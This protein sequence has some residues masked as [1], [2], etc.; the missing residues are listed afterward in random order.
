VRTLIHWFRR[1]LRVADNTAL[2][3]A[4]RDAERVVPVFLLDDHYAADP[5][6]GPARL[7]FL[8]ESLEEL[9]LSLPR[10]GGS[11]LVRRG[12]AAT[13]LPQLLAETGADGVYANLEIG[14]YPE[15]RDRLAQAAVEAAGARFRLFGDA[16]LV[17][18]DAIASAAGDPYTVYTPFSRK[19]TAAEKRDPEPSPAS[20]ESPELPGIPLATVRAWRDLPRDARCLPGGETAALELLRRFFGGPAALY[21]ED[22]NRPDRE[23][24]SRLSPYL[25]FGTISPRTIRAAAE[26]SW[27]A[28]PPGGREHI[29]KFVLELAW[30]EFYQHVLFHFPRVARESFRPEFDALAWKDDAEAL[31]AWK[32]GRTGY[33]FVDASMRELTTTHWMHNRSRMV[34]AS[35]LTKD[36]HIHWRQGEQWFEH[37][38]ADADLA[39]NNGGW[40]WAAGSGTDAAPYF[41]VFNPVLQ[42]RKFDPEGSYIR[43]YVPE[44]A[45]VPAGKLH[46]PWTMTS[47]EQV[48]SGC[49]IGVDYPAPIVDHAREKAVALEMFA[50]LRK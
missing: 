40:Q 30:R 35:F 3:R 46:E 11:L 41:R 49:R 25:H 44:L 29:R 17:E 9:A 18:P 10:A 14:P 16:L 4:A 19:W 20:L 36:L 24:T 34:A 33:P 2:S 37:E 39:S 22:R 31:L 26:E 28:T 23:G 1:D 21:A 12:P 42:S 50:A 43:R 38:L 13:A 45:R 6:V 5:N 27:R 15:E 8:R 47:G 32:R 48:E 7:R